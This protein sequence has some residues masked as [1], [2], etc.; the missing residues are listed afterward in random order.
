MR[1]YIYFPP[2]SQVLYE[3]DVH[4]HIF[5]QTWQ[6][7]PHDRDY[8]ISLYLSVY[9]GINTI[10]VLSLFN[11]FLSSFSSDFGLVIPAYEIHK[12]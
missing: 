11:F 1:T 4:I 12:R 3:L 5:F 9:L 10:I 2:Y 7:L 8:I 6:P